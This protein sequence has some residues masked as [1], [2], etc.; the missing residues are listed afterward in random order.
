MRSTGAADFEENLYTMF[1]LD[2]FH[3][4]SSVASGIQSALFG[5]TEIQG[6]V[7]CAYEDFRKRYPL[8]KE[9]HS[10]FQN[11]LRISKQVR[12]SFSNHNNF[13]QIETLLESKISSK[14]GLLPKTGL[15][16]GASSIN[17][18]IATH[19][20]KNTKHRISICNRCDLRAQEF[21]Q[22]L[23][24][25]FVEWN[26]WKQ[27][28]SNFDWV[29]TAVKSPTYILDKSS[30]ERFSNSLFI[31]LGV[32]RNIDPSCLDSCLI[33]LEDLTTKNEKG[34]NRDFISK[35]LESIRYE[36]EK[37]LSQLCQKSKAQI[38]LNDFSV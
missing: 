9:L 30:I 38:L 7:R 34:I 31:D 27:T 2:A 12:N 13:D 20:S 8:S 16:V 23:S 29:I 14:L 1:N 33:H 26:Q 17:K 22:T 10:L 6:Q 25:D 11:A 19:F 32:P 35:S 28:L 24:I 18:K 3:H 4:L 37:T 21:A 15:I 36:A 5:E